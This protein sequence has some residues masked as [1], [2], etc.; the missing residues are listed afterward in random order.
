MHFLL[1]L[2]E[3][4][5]RFGFLQYIVFTMHLDI[6]HMFLC[7]AKAM[8][9]GKPKQLTVWNGGSTCPLLPFVF[10]WITFVHCVFFI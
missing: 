7:I 3:I 5:S 10:V 1:P 2:F 8:Y 9:L 6:A 4:V